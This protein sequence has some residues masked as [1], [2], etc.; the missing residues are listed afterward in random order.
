[1]LPAVIAIHDA[2]AL[3]IQLHPVAAVTATLPDPPSAANAL[4]AGAIVYEH[5]GV[6]WVGES[7]PPQLKPPMN[8]PIPNKTGST[9]LI[10]ILDLSARHSKRRTNELRPESAVIVLVSTRTFPRNRARW[11]EVR[12][13]R[14]ISHSCA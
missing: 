9:R 2:L 14:N 4:S 11:E 1:L 8:N 13:P 12:G 10:R 6:G 3:A 7:A 5:T